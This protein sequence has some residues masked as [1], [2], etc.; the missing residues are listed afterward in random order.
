MRPRLLF[1]LILTAPFGLGMATCGGGGGFT[2]EQIDIQVKRAGEIAAETARRKSEQE[3]RALQEKLTETEREKIKAIADDAERKKQLDAL[4]ARTEAL[5][6]QAG[7]QAAE[8]AK[9]AAEDATRLALEKLKAEQKPGQPANNG[10]LLG[11]LGTALTT[12]ALSFVE[13]KARSW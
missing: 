7:D 8:L 1:F 3:I 10:G 5:V 12:V 2:Q 9:K 11:L 13:A 4:A 6:K